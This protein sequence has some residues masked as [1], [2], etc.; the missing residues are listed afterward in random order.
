[1]NTKQILAM[2]LLAMGSAQAM[3]ST[4]GGGRRL[5][6][7]QVEDMS[8]NIAPKQSQ[9]LPKQ[10]QG[11]TFDENLARKYFDKMLELSAK[12][13]KL[14]KELLQ[15]Q[16]NAEKRD[17]SMEIQ[18]MNAISEKEKL[19]SELSSQKAL[20]TKAQSDLQKK[21]DD[22]QGLRVSDE[23]L[24]S[25]H[26]D[27]KRIIDAQGEQL[28]AVKVVI[29]KAARLKADDIKENVANVTPAMIGLVKDKLKQK[30]GADGIDTAIKNI[31]I[32]VG[33][34]G[35]NAIFSAINV[36]QAKEL[37]DKLFAAIG[38][39]AGEVN[40]V[41]DDALKVITGTDFEAI[42]DER[43]AVRELKETSEN[44]E[45]MLSPGED[46]ETLELK[47][48][49]DYIAGVPLKLKRKRGVDGV[50]FVS[51]AEDFNTFPAVEKAKFEIG[52]FKEENQRLIE[53][54][55]AKVKAPTLTSKKFD[56]DDGFSLENF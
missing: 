56:A 30:V 19:E 16:E 27:A 48:V 37:I 5:I 39:K 18:L 23:A 29:E 33:G 40:V 7:S 26:K 21:R 15:M 12:G 1:M 32:D 20:L 11:L 17:R 41:A 8:Q 14:E 52:K 38:L 31:S 53:Q 25:M 6:N 47:N 43:D 4:T 3:Q 46:G 51:G 36:Q 34:A 42:N 45:V 49:V 10:S 24:K 9:G 28:S 44:V 55:S 50:E 13:S 35:A 54:I 2:A 22:M